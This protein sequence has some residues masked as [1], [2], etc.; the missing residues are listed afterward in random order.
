MF[1][2]PDKS[3][4]F[5]L[6]VSLALIALTCLGNILLGPE[7]I[8]LILLYPVLLRLTILRK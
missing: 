2:L 6:I 7:A 1:I 4:T 3:S 8:L 5:L